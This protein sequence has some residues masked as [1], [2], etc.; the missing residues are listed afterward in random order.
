MVELTN[1]FQELVKG[2]KQEQEAIRSTVV[3]AF[4]SF[5]DRQ[6]SLPSREYDE[7]GRSPNR[8]NYSRDRMHNDHNYRRDRSVSP[9]VNRSINYNIRTP[10]RAQSPAGRPPRSN[11]FQRSSSPGRVQ[12]STHA[13]DTAAYYEKFGKPPGPCN[14]CGLM[15]W[16]RH[17]PETSN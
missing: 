14:G 12:G 17:C 15:H 2:M 7:R 1:M 8:N 13:F 3:A 10:P 9:Q 11:Y 4:K 16:S 5:E 6:M